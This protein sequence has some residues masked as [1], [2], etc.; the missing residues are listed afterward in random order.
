[1]WACAA[2]DLAL[3]TLVGAYIGIRCWRKNCVNVLVNNHLLL[4]IAKSR[5][6]SLSIRGG[7]RSPNIHEVAK[8]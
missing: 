8:D 5:M 3:V 4:S 2:L 7:S 1:V 6:R